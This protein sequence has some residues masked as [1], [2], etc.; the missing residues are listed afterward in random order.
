MAD[1]RG[2][3]RPKAAGKRPENGLNPLGNG[4]KDLAGPIRKIPVSELRPGMRVVNTGLSWIDHPYLYS[5]EGQIGSD[6]DIQSIRDQGYLE[7][8][9][10]EGPGA[11]GGQALPGAAATLEQILATRDFTPLT[12]QRR[13]ATPEEYEG[14]QVFYSQSLSFAREFI[15]DVSQGKPVDYEASTPLVENIIDSVSRNPDTLVSLTKLRCF[16][17]YT[18]THCINVAVL[19]VI[20]GKFLGLGRSALH[21]MGMAGLFHDIGKALIPADILNKPGR[22]TDLEFRMIQNHPDLG[23]T[24]LA[25]QPGVPPVVISGVKE[26]HEKFN[27]TGYPRGLNG[28]TVS[29]A[30]A[31]I[32]VV[33]VYDALTSKRTYKNAIT[34]NNAMRIMFG[35]RGRGFSRGNGG[36]LHQVPGHLPRGHPGPP[37]KRPGGRGGGLQ[38]G[39]PPVSHGEDHPHQG[40]EPLEASDRGPDLGPGQGHGRRLVHHGHSGLLRPGGGPHGLPDVKQAESAS[41]LS[42]CNRS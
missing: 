26:H 16:D 4:Q 18:F 3:P 6:E 32:G 19:A 22:L 42:A 7:L 2:W 23:A 41:A 38:H 29:L 20:F 31:V 12:P 36:G 5:Q 15:K 17:E 40:S 34:P 24:H 30:G 13:P 35:M 14:A 8:F 27:G 28:M 25:Q 21:V 33:D 10:A 1:T 37:G 39:Q 11:G 9:I